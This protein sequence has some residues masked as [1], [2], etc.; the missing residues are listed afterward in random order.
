MRDDLAFLETLFSTTNWH[1]QYTA[2]EAIR[3]I[4]NRREAVAKARLLVA[5]LTALQADIAKAGMIVDTL[6]A[7]VLV[8]EVQHGNR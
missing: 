4:E 5:E 7:G 8:L 3:E 2:Y 6:P 1:D